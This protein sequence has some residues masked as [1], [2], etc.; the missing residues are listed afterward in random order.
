MKCGLC[1]LRKAK[2]HCPAK[3]ALICPQCCAEKRVFEIDCPENCAY[4]IAGRERDI[5]EYTRCIGRLDASDHDRNSR[6]FRDHPDALARLEY[7]IASERI[8]SPELT[9]NDVA[10]AVDILLDTYRTE[11][12]GVLYEK[13]SD[14]F[15]VEP[16]RRELRN[17]IESLR[18]PE[19]GE[20]NGIV[21]PQ[22]SRLQLSVAIDCLECIRS[23][24]VAFQRGAQSPAGYVNFLAR[25]LPRKETRSPIVL[26]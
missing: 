17:A 19:R 6:V 9:D 26:A 3:N 22:S 14:D 18:N 8:S 24:V 20:T 7:A 10:Q 23:M 13:T 25:V 2:R 15:R 4:L 1:D 21:D 12:N 16:M 11:A 5:A